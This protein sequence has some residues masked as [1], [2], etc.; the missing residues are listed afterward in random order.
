MIQPG[1]ETERVRPV[2][3]QAIRIGGSFVSR[4]GRLRRRADGLATARRKLIAGLGQPPGNF[5]ADRFVGW[6]GDPDRPP[7]VGSPAM[8]ATGVVQSVSGLQ[9]VAH[10]PRGRWLGGSGAEHLKRFR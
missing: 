9:I 2:D 6:P 3:G 8:A 5:A 10:G 7:P 4:Y 1:C